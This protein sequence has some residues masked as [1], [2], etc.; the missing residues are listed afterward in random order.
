M[1]AH[2]RIMRYFF[3]TVVD[4][5]NVTLLDLRFVWIFVNRIVQVNTFLRQTDGISYSYPTK[6]ATDYNVTLG[7]GT[8]H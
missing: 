2:E 8:Y 7:F 1:L 6:P 5:A 4:L 3:Y